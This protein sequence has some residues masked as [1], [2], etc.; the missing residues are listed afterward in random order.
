MSKNRLRRSI[1][2]FFGSVLSLGVVGSST[3][4]AQYPQRPI[5]LVVPYAAGGSSDI[6][7]RQ[8][9]R[10]LEGI[11][12]QPVIVEN[13][14]GAGGAVGAQRVTRAD[15]DGYTLLIGAGSELLI[16]KHLQPT[17]YDAFK[18]F[19]ALGLIGTGPMVLVG[20]TSLPSQDVNSLFDV[21]MTRSDPMNYGSAGHGTFMHL[22]GEAVKS[23]KKINIKHVPYRGA[24]PVMNDIIAGHLDLGVASL[25]SAL[26]FIA[27]DKARAY[28]VTSAGRTEFAPQIPALS[29]ISGLSDFN[30]ELWIGLFGPAGLPEDISTKLEQATA[31]ALDSPELKQKLADQAIAVRKMS[32]SEFAAYL[33]AEDKKY[34]EI[35]TSGNITNQQ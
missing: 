11:L 20:K 25:A 19:K 3:A 23:K 12:G 16:R 34:K 9:G 31:T 8:F 4:F 1:S 29:E 2:L 6:V 22:V 18:D 26:P 27:S 15:P 7:A 33:N 14:T 24:A 10:S 13:V 5:T 32:S 21:L 17:P 30:L 35:I 28:A